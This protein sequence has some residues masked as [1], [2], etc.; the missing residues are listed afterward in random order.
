MSALTVCHPPLSVVTCEEKVL[1]TLC[2]VVFVQID[3]AAVSKYMDMLKVSGVHTSQAGMPA[4]TASVRDGLL[5]NGYLGV[6]SDKSAVETFIRSVFDSEAKLFS[7]RVGAIPN[8]KSTAE[9]LEVMALAGISSR[10]WASK[11]ISAVKEHLTGLIKE[12]GGVRSFSLDSES[13]DRERFESNVFSLVAAKYAGVALPSPRTFVQFF[14]DRAHPRG[15]VAVAAGAIPT[16]DSTVQSVIALS[17]LEKASGYNALA[18]LSTDSMM[19]VIYPV[20]HDLH[21]SGQAHFAFSHMPNFKEVFHTSVTFDSASNVPIDAKNPNIVQGTKITPFV[22][23]LPFNQPHAGLNMEA[24]VSHASGADKKYKLHWNPERFGYTTEETFDTSSKLGEL[25]VTV[26]VSV[27]TASGD[28]VGFDIHEKFNI[29]YTMTVKPAAKVAGRDIKPGESVTVGTEFSFDVSLTAGA[30]LTSGNFELVFSVL[31][32][33]EVVV[34][35]SSKN[36]AKSGAETVHFA[37]DL[38]RANLPSG[39]LSFKFHVL[40]LSTNTVHTQQRVEYDLQLTMVASH[41]KIGDGSSHMP[42]FKLGDE[43]VVTMVPASFPDLVN[44]HTYAALDATGQDVS[45]KR[46]FFLDT[47]ESDTVLRAFS[48]VATQ[49]ASTGNVV[50]KFTVPFPAVFDAIGKHQIRFRYTPASGRDVVLRSYDSAANELFDVEHESSLGF[51]VKSELYIADLVDAP[52]GGDLSYGDPVHFSFKVKDR[53]TGDYVTTIG[54]SS[55]VSLALSHKESAGKTYVSARHAA[56]VDPR[57]GFVIDWTV[58]PNAIAGKGVLQLR[59]VILGGEEIV[60]PTEDGK[61]FA[62]N[63]KIGGDISHSATVKQVSVPT[64]S[65]GAAVVEFELKCQNRLLTGALLIAAIHKNGQYVGLA[66]VARSEEEA[67]YSV[68][69]VIPEA[70]AASASYQ[71]AIHRQ[72]DKSG[73]KPLFTI[74]VSFVGSTTHYLPFRTEAVILTLAL[75]SFGFFSYRKWIIERKQQN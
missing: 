17:A 63:V 45:Q 30:A 19:Q 41:I 20:P 2:V 27:P 68:S 74:P 4:T 64:A 3:V 43:A 5:V 66:P 59:A 21:K 22:M 26:K 65:H 67:Q 35:Q 18:S 47:L 75:T 60:L 38:K 69:W 6:S 57:G 7:A 54:A 12:D 29:G 44:L 61:A 32:S 39:L 62:V 36:F 14:L 42:S 40:D 8:A 28:A 71:I 52:K 15:G 51:D 1:L 10:D 56:S 13:S 16:L 23:A 73:D 55:S 9:A 58:N 49:D 48:G 25:S 24:V 46:A 72:A 31:D 53:L 37:Y 34:E 11:A 33:S 50:V 70:D